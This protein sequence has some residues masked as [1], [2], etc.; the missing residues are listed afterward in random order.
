MKE[1][2]N[3]GRINPNLILFI[4][5]AL[6]IA[7]GFWGQY[8]LKLGG[9]A[10]QYFQ[11]LTKGKD[12]SFIQLTKQIDKLSADE[13]SYHGQL[14]DLNSLYLSLSGVNTIKKE[15]CTIVR[16]ASDTLFLP[17]P[18]QTEWERNTIASAVK[19]LQEL[20]EDNGSSF[21]YA[22][23]PKK[24]NFVTAPSRIEDYERENLDAF[25]DKLHEQGVSYLDLREG[26][27]AYS[28][29]PEELYFATDH[30]WTPYAGFLANILI[31]EEL[32]DRYG[33]E[34]RQE[35]L[36]IENYNIETYEDYFLG[37][38]GKKAGL[39]FC[40]GRA[41]NFDLITP[42]FHTDMTEEQPIKNQF[43]EGS[44]EETALFMENLAQKDYYNLNPY[45]TYC[46]GDF[47]LQILKDRL[48]TEGKKILVIR[49][50]FAGA[51]CPFTAL[52][53]SEVHIMDIRNFGYYVGEKQNIG[54]YIRE[55]QPDYV[56]LLYSVFDVTA[57]RYS[58]FE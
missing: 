35:A 46:G 16:T 8:V 51:V 2:K 58:F 43:R 3:T 49:D 34:P 11:D 55:I 57:G 31:C 56:V 25:M 15:D 32:S 44:F 19:K 20:V 14:M 38:H 18:K 5:C 12:A 29:N 50:S 24:N 53:F 21:L 54:D 42:K 22:I 48:N 6:F 1:K 10:L 26:L 27:E 45:A 36:N 39:Y 52:Q 37:S 13:L 30:H 40:R 17:A 28:D 33:F 41:D 47:R 23:A 7:A 9:Q 4:A